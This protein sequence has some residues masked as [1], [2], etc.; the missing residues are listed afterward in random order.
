MDAACLCCRGLAEEAEADCTAVARSVLHCGNTSATMTDDVDIAE[1]PAYPDFSPRDTSVAGLAGMRP[2]DQ[3][4]MAGKEVKPEALVTTDHM[5]THRGDDDHQQQPA[6]VGGTGSNSGSHK[7]AKKQDIRKRW[8]L[9]LGHRMDEDEVLNRVWWCL[10]C[11]CAGCGCTRQ[12]SPLNAMCRCVLC[13]SRCSTETNDTCLFCVQSFLCCISQFRCPP[14]QG[15][16]RCVLGK[17]YFCGY[18]G[19]LRSMVKH[20]GE[21]RDSELDKISQTIL[22]EPC[23]CHAFCCSCAWA[24]PTAVNMISKCMGCL[25]RLDV[26]PACGNQG[27]CRL[28]A[29]CWWLHMQCRVPPLVQSNPICALCGLRCRRSYTHY[30]PPEQQVMN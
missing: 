26:G 20:Q 30:A 5:N 8:C 28:L 17:F 12:P 13:I 29:Q 14:Q 22:E 19:G 11:C 9:P 4:A 15:H 2:M 27:I 1:A 3:I 18:V 24:F 21:Q 10:Y 23:L 16:P 25:C 6:L 7:Q